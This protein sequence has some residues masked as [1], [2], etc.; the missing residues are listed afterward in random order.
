MLTHQEAQ[1][2]LSHQMTLLTIKAIL[3]LNS[4]IFLTDLFATCIMFIILFPRLLIVK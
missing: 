2:F 1:H 3:L 4:F